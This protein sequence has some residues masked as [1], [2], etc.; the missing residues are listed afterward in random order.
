MK[1]TLIY[2][3]IKDILIVLGVGSAVMESQTTQI[4]YSPLEY[5]CNHMYL[6]PYY[7]KA[8]KLIN[9]EDALK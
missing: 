1:P 2:N 9:G 6:N 5:L 7:W 3:K 4:V 8:K